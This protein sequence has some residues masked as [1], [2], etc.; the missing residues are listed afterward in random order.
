MKTLF[1]LALIGSTAYAEPK[2]CKQTGQPVVALSR[3]GETK[4]SKDVASP[5]ITGGFTIWPTGGYRSFEQ[6][7]DTNK[8][9][10]E[11]T[12]CLDDAD[13]TQVK[14][15]LAKAT[16]KFT[17][18]KIK[19]MVMSVNHTEWTA[20]DKLVWDDKMC[21]GQLADAATQNAIDLVHS[22]A[23]KVTTDRRRP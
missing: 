11:H 15:V 21:S 5:T 22:L 12:G 10:N 8:I 1:V 16:W 20:N 4:P 14:A 9:T 23:S 19:C 2:V 13:F 7:P 6:D 3:L 18:A 17:T